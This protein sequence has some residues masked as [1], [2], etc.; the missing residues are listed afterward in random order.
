MT[1]V[2]PDI[3][4]FLHRANQLKTIERYKSSLTEKGDT[5][6][7]HSWRLALMVLVVGTELDVPVNIPHAMK[8]ALIHDLAELKTDDIDAYEVIKQKVKL[9]D[10]QQKE[11]DAMYEIL[12]GISFGDHI[13]DTWKE[14]EDQET[15]E[16]KFVKALDKIEAFLHLDEAGTDVYFPK[17]FHGDYADAAV[18]AFDGAVR[19]FPPLE[20]LLSIVKA[21]L[22]KKFEANGVA[23]VEGGV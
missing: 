9:E 4:T 23:W 10:K 11:R 18:H 3:L 12:R 21:E 22:K 13:L 19:H 6:A 2:I 15:V 16:A 7:D 8:M 14:Y 5:V 1:T 17:E 20:G